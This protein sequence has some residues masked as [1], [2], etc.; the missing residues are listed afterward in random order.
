M[1]M[2]RHR[3]VKNQ[4]TIKLRV[5]IKIIDAANTVVL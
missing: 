2:E 3:L 1:K 5:V 4:T